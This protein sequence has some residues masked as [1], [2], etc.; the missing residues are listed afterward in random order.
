MKE[1]HCCI[2]CDEVSDI[3]LFSVKE[4]PTVCYYDNQFS[5]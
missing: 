3:A 2:F 1:V 5:N 4:Y